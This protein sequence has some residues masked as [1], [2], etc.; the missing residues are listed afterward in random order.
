I[1]HSGSTYWRKKESEKAEMFKKIEP[2]LTF[3]DFVK[4]ERKGADIE[5]KLTEKEK[6]IQLLRQRDTINT[7]AIANLSDQVMKLMLEVKQV[8][9]KQKNQVDA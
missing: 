5:T 6:E 9:Q 4:L 1:S 2:Y 7:D 3:L 8:K